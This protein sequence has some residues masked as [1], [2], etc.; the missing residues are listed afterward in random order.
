MQ[1]AGS[2]LLDVANTANT[3]SD[4]RPRTWGVLAGRGPRQQ[5][6][7]LRRILGHPAAR[8]GLVIGF[9]VAG[10]EVASVI[11][12]LTGKFTTFPFYAAVV[13]SAWFGI[14]PGVA[15]FILSALSAA[16]F[17][18]PGRFD[19]HIGAAELPS[20]IAFICFALLSLA[21]SSQRRRAQRTLEATVQQRTADLLRTNAAL[22]VEI[23]ERE[24]AEEELRHS[25]TLLAQGQKLSR[26]ASWLL[27]L[28]EGDMQWSAQLFDILGLDRASQTPSYRLFTERMHPDDRRRFAEA[29]E[30]AI[31]ANSDFSC[32]ARIVIPGAATK[33]VQAIGEVRRGAAGRGEFIG[34][35][36]DLTERKR[37]EQALR[38]AESELAHALRL[39]TVAELA[40]AIAHEIN[41]P[42]AAITANGSACLRSLV[43]HPPMLD[44]AREA[45]GCIVAD[46]HRAG[47]VIAR[48]RALFN[49]EEPKQQML[50]IN[51]IVQHVLDLS[52][53]AIDQQ[54]V[55]ARIKLA[56]SPLMVT[57]DPVQ[58]QQVIVNLVTNALEAMSGIVD[59]P[60]RLTIRSEVERGAAVV[61]TIE[62]SGRGLAPEQMSRIFD[63]FYTTKPDGIG[64]GLAISRSIIEAHGGSL[65]AFPGTRYGARVG[66]TLPR[67]TANI[68]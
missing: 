13:A 40:A 28:P 56:P 4:P 2:V 57:G 64:V 44:N 50:D 55:I 39:A 24:T 22:Q 12:G 29:V 52:R 35:I 6:S 51:D 9:V 14:G 38:D 23:A 60:R 21:W 62:D 20:F 16:D 17:L 5:P 54:R 33:Y 25:E 66:F 11:E 45:A 67:A 49:K 26:T 58:L 48:I 46:G 53:G 19:I 15:A 43:N 31:E 27:H 1:A 8:Y 3:P 18:T 63:S 36:M 34:T 10:A 37:T 65:W 32:E 42:L 61:L 30:R 59:W 7:F 68:A 41:Q 47:D